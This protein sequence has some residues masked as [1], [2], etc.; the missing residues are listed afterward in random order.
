MGSIHGGP[1]LYTYKYFSS[2]LCPNSGANCHMYMAIFICISLL[3]EFIYLTKYAFT[4]YNKSTREKPVRR[5]MEQGTFLGNVITQDQLKLDGP[6]F[7]AL[8]TQ[9]QLWIL[10]YLE[11]LS[12]QATNTKLNLP[13]KNYGSLLKQPKI[14]SALKEICAPIMTGHIATIREVAKFLTNCIDAKITDYC[15]WDENG[16]TIYHPS[17]ELTDEQIKAIREIDITEVQ[18]RGGIRRNMKIRLHDPL[19]A[20]ELLGKYHGMFQEKVEH[21]GEIKITVEKRLKERDAIDV[22]HS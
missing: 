17:N 8:D 19:R 15:S 7:T 11:T 9:H 3:D 20:A 10:T 13:A 14:Q 18:T 16:V 4:W 2:F 12:P 21:T 5:R 6:M 1:I 22:S